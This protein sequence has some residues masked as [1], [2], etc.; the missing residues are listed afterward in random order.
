VKKR[1]PILCALV[2]AFVT[3][4]LVAASY[5]VPPDDVFVRKADVVV[6]ARAESSYVR[7]TPE[8]GIETVY[9]FTV[10]ETLEGDSQT[11]VTLSIPGGAINGHFKMIGGAPTFEIGTEYLLFLTARG[12]GRHSLTDF[13]LGAFEFTDDGHRRLVQRGGDVVGWDL[14]G[15]PHRERQRDAAAFL[16]YIREIGR[17]GTPQANYFVSHA[18]TADQI[19]DRA[20]TATTSFSGTTYTSVIGSPAGC[21]A[22]GCGARWN[23]FPSPVSWTMGN[24]EPGAPGSPAGQTAVAAAFGAWNGGGANIN[25]TLGATN[26]GNL[27]GITD[28]ADGINNIVFEKDLSQFAPAFSCSTGGLLG[29]GGVSNGTTPLNTKN[30]ENYF[31][32][33][34]V[35]V[36]MNKGI[37]NCT[38]LFNSGDF[39]SA[40]THEVGHTLGFRHSDQDRNNTPG[41]TCNSSTM[42]CTNTAIMNHQVPNGLNAHLQTWDLNA[43]ATV[44]GS[45]P[46]CTNPGISVQPA[47][48]TITQGQSANLSVTAT[49][50]S[51]TYIWYVGNPP[52]TSSPVPGGTSASIFV[53]PTSTT[54]YWVRVS[55][56][57]TSVDSN[58][59]TV[60][61]NQ[62]VCNAPQITGQPQNQTTTSGNSA[63][64]TVNATGTALTYQWFNGNSG[65]TSSPVQ[66]GTFATIFVSPTTTTNYWV[67][68]SG[69]CGTP[70]NSNTVTVTI[71]ACPTP[72]ISGASA[73][74]SA[75]QVGQSSS[76]A[77]TVTNAG[78][79]S[80][81]YVGTPPDKSN[82]VPQSGPN[83]TVT[84][85]TTTTYWLQA[86]SSCGAASVNSNI[87]TVTVGS[88]PP[89]CV[90]PAIS[91]QPPSQQVVA[92]LP[93]TLTVTASGTTPLHYQWYKGPTGNKS[94][95]TG[96]DSSS[97]TT[98]AI[99]STTQYW[100]EVTNSC[101][102]GVAQSATATLTPFVSRHRSTR[103]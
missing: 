9:E 45:G 89:P 56:C 83:V 28:A 53:S 58:A 71:G 43:V 84:P 31:T 13:A 1:F 67:R 63:Q 77:A 16:D 44:Y 70:Q 62:P 51:P 99:N 55:A 50:T 35:D 54:N 68:V 34:E 48:S 25:Y 95:P 97:F 42:E 30:G 10:A 47:G 85:A 27:K 87:V 18:A 39:N 57:S 26:T 66:G 86:V 38:A 20:H 7:E 94:T 61:V 60:T 93:T 49:G 72:S 91:T 3:L 11:K 6:L 102:N 81:W 21:P 88:T 40:V 90:P 15:E 37:A 17:G 24:T 2:C 23:S 12:A 103:H 75:I 5:V 4:P 36:S 69:Q 96:T 52:S 92:G 19:D 98:D 33:T 32:T 76:L 100:V 74:P 8:S 64:L 82:P 79:G 14:D 80:Q 101:T 73:V 46:V 59:A 78:G 22:G 65:D 29:V 41:N